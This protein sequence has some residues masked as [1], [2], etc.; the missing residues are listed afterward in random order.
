MVGDIGV[1][2]RLDF[3]CSFEEE[4]KVRPNLRKTLS[5]LKGTL[6]GILFVI[7]K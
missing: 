1:S 7:M 5:I 2:T 6:N 3:C 4:D